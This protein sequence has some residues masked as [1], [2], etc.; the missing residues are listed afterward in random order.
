MLKKTIII[1]KLIPNII[2]YKNQLIYMI[3]VWEPKEEK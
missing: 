1:K 3:A 2:R